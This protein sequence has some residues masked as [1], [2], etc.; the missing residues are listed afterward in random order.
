MDLKTAS[1]A[2]VIK[3]PEGVDPSTVTSRAIQNGSGL[4]IEGNKGVEE[5]AKE[6]DCKFAVKLDRSEFKPEEINV[7]LRGQELTITGKH[8]SEDGGFHLSRHYSR[9]IR[10]PD[11]ADVSSVTS[12]LSK[13]AC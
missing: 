7:E 10:L 4:L 12:R 2:K 5:M 9:R 6:D 13:E 11:D 8:R 1:S 3:L